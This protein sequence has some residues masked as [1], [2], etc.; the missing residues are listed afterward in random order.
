MTETTQASTRRI[1]DSTGAYKISGIWRFIAS[2]SNCSRT[3]NSPSYK[4]EEGRLAPLMVIQKRNKSRRNK[5]GNPV[6]LL[7]K[8]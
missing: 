4:R 7:V 6:F 2:F 1:P 5:M 3:Q 8:I